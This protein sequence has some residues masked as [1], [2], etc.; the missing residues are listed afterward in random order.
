MCEKK[1]KEKKKKEKRK[2]KENEKIGWALPENKLWICLIK[3]TI[4]SLSN[5]YRFRKLLVSFLNNDR[6]TNKMK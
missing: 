2:K 3:L 6:F 4:V 1:K 5:L